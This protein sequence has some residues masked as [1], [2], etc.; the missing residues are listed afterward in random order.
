[1]KHLNRWVYAIV[2][3]IVLLMAGLVYAWS[4][5]SRS[6]GMSRPQWTAARLS[7][8]F[9]LVMV[10][11]CIGCLVAGI[12]SNKINPKIYILASGILFFVGFFI[13]SRTGI[14]PALLYIGF[15]VF[16][17]LGAGV[18]YNAIMSTMSAWFPDKQ[19]LISGILLMGFGISSFLIGNIFTAVTP[20]DGS[21]AWQTTFWILGIIILVI[22]VICALIFKKPEPGYQPE[23]KPTS[24]QKRKPREPASEIPIGQMARKPTFWMYYLWAIFVSAEGLVLV[25]QASGIATEVGI[26]FSAGVIATVVGL[27]SIFNGVGRVIFG[28]LY[29]RAGYRVTMLTDMAIFFVAALILVFA[30]RSGSF[31]LIVIGFVVGGLGYGGV[32]PTNSALISDFF[33]RKNYSLNFSLVNTNLLIASFASTIAGRLYDSSGSYMTTIIMMIICVAIGFVCFFGV[34]RPKPAAEAAGAGDGAAEAAAQAAESA[35]DDETK[36]E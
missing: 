30:L 16:C 15:G 2:G 31:A 20:V 32:T 28:A 26:G 4:V 6:I 33:G 7:L 5:M 24:K 29:D 19:G 12:L 23:S 8:T 1:M 13:A 34:R 27:V 10:F 18:A 11:F 25:S 21:N 3:V 17:G 36:S 9:T 14:T 35:A 22:L